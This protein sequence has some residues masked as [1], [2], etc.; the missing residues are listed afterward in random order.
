MPYINHSMVIFGILICFVL[1]YPAM[2]ENPEFELEIQN[3]GESMPEEEFHEISRLTA[4]T[5]KTEITLL[6]PQPHSIKLNP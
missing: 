4:V 5:R 6:N 2:F 1:K 3:A